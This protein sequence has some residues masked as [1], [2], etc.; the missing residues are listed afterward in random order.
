M[1]KRIRGFFSVAIGLSMIMGNLTSPMY[2]AAGAGKAEAMPES[3][4]VEIIKESSE[5]ELTVVDTDGNPVSPD[6]GAYREAMELYNGYFSGLSG[7]IFD[8][9][10]QDMTDILIEEMRAGAEPASDNSDEEPASEYSGA[11][12]GSES[13]ETGSGSEEAAEL[14]EVPDYSE[15]RLESD[16]SSIKNPVISSGKTTW[17]CIWFGSHLRMKGNEDNPLNLLKWRVLEVKDGEALLLCEGNKDETYFNRSNKMDTSYGSSDLKKYVDEKLFNDAFSPIEKEALKPVKENDLITIPSWDDMKNAAYGFNS[18]DTRKWGRKYWVSDSD[19]HV[20]YCVSESGKKW[21]EDPQM[22]AGWRWMYLFRSQ[23][24]YGVRPMV[25]LDLSKT[26]VWQ[27]AGTVCS[28]G[29]VSNVD[30]SGIRTVKLDPLGGT[31]KNTELKLVNDRITSDS[32]AGGLSDAKKEGMDFEGWFDKEKGGKKYVKGSLIPGDVSVL[33]AHYSKEYTGDDF[34]VKGEKMSVDLPGGKDIPFLSHGLEI[35]FAGLN[36]SID[37]DKE[38]GTYEVGIGFDIKAVKDNVGERGF[39]PKK[40]FGGEAKEMEENI[41]KAWEALSKARDTN[42][43]KPIKVSGSL[44][45]SIMLMGYAEGTVED[46]GLSAPTTGRIVLSFELYY[47]GQWQTAIVFIP[48]TIRLKFGGAGTFTLEIEKTEEGAYDLSGHAEIIFPDIELRAGVGLAYVAS[49]GVYGSGKSI[50]DMKFKKPFSGKWS[51]EGEAGGYAS[52]LFLDYKKC[53]LR[54]PIEITKWGEYDDKDKKS[55]ANG[56]DLSNDSDSLR[57]SFYEGGEYSITRTGENAIRDWYPDGEPEDG[58]LKAVNFND[59]SLSDGRVTLLEHMYNN[60]TPD[61]IQTKDKTVMAFTADDS[62]DKT[63]N[64]TNVYYSVW[65]KANEKWGDSQ[66]IDDAHTSAEFYPDLAAGGSGNDIWAVWM[67]AGKEVSDKESAILEG[68]GGE[69]LSKEQKDIIQKIT[70]SMEIK[71]ASFNSVTGRFENP[72]TLNADIDSAMNIKPKIAFSGDSPYVVWLSDDNLNI[73][74]STEDQKDTGRELIRYAYKG[75]S[76]W[77][78][79]SFDPGNVSVTDLNIGVLSGKPV[80]VY[81]ADMD[82]DL[83]TLDDVRLYTVS[84]EDPKS[85]GETKLISDEKGSEADN[86]QFVNICGKEAVIWFERSGDFFKGLKYT[87]DPSAK[88]KA[89]LFYDESALSPDF[90]AFDDTAFEGDPEETAT[91]II[92]CSAP[93]SDYDSEEETKDDNNAEIFVYVVTEADEEDKKEGDYD[94]DAG[95]PI[96][97]KNTGVT[98]SAGVPGAFWKEDNKGDLSDII[99]VYPETRADSFVEGGGFNIETSLYMTSV[100]NDADITIDEDDDIIDIEPEDIAVGSTV[101]FNFTVKNSGF[102]PMESIKARLKFGDQVLYDDFVSLG[103]D[104]I[105]A[106]DS[107]K[108]HIDVLIPDDFEPEPGAELELVLYDPDTDDDDDPDTGNDPDPDDKDNS[109]KFNVGDTNLVLTQEVV[110]DDSTVSVNY[111]IENTS[112]YD[113][114]GVFGLYRKE[115]DGEKPLFDPVDVE[116]PAKESITLCLDEMAVSE[117]AEYGDVIFAKV[118]TE[119]EESYTGDNND[120]FKVTQDYIDEVKVNEGSLELMP[121]ESR[122][123]SASVFPEKLS[124][125]GVYWFSTDEN[126]AVVDRNGC[127]T[128][129]G[130]GSAKIIAAA[131]DGGGAKA[132]ITV[133]VDTCGRAALGDTD[134][135]SGQGKKLSLDLPEDRLEAVVTVAKGNKFTILNAKPKSFTYDVPGDKKLVGVSKKGKVSAKKASEGAVIRYEDAR[136]GKNIKLTVRVM[137]QKFTEAKKLTSNVTVGTAFDISAELLLNAEFKPKNEKYKEVIPDL[138]YETDKKGT[139]H[140]TGTPAK[141]GTVS[142]PVYAYGKK[143]VMKIKAK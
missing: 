126:V 108:C 110:T 38:E 89:V 17:D 101:S 127:V 50:V 4:E 42:F 19:M 82:R 95:Y 106:G 140:I 113:T 70:G 97:I 109:I 23:A 111:I 73:G 94:Y 22:T 6:S 37:V 44:D 85:P 87:T 119:S 28:D 68:I 96:R 36:A 40:Y 67:D 93:E 137:E 62:G 27:N 139:W 117:L 116:I 64:H 121:G 133:K 63:G 99:L 15:T 25:R 60:P 21:R 10:D 69:S 30:P 103:G 88:G 71:A 47:N 26:D 107:R 49:I 75:G 3:S 14:F 102:E 2:A 131:N 11:E 84:L 135:L 35:D 43:S 7:K 20:N 41:T 86:P 141:K 51:L 138:K 114:K 32:P 132:E 58:I 24:S 98:G 79:G 16:P 55:K 122:T 61:V 13:V 12:G 130:M 1:N 80:I 31:V 83:N 104:P 57:G 90:K 29:T 134:V 112:I 33:Y 128:G 136:T 129:V 9:S 123:L 54:K 8:L 76:E 125:I 66:N 120:L 34:K 53:F 65:D 48:V 59:G 115:G 77:K 91:T 142:I 39:S 78:Y 56:A 118:T 105:L 74:S 46:G 124:D 143:F 5:A 81:G 18:D 72:E 100:L 52:F 92:C 45:P